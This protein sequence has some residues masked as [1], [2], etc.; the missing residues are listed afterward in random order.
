MDT[1]EVIVAG[2]DEPAALVQDVALVDGIPVR[3]EARKQLKVRP[4]RWCVMEGLGKNGVNEGA[5]K[6]AMFRDAVVGA[7]G[8]DA[9]TPLVLTDPELDEMS[10]RDIERLAGALE[11]ANLVPDL[12]LTGDCPHC[13]AAFKRS[14]DWGYD[15]FFRA[16][17]R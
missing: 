7:E 13:G 3:G 14:L 10:K 1:L 2:T 12:A 16:S 8:V 9:A 5:M 11:E 17:S 4:I 15:A 6:V